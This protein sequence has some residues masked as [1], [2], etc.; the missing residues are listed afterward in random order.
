MDGLSLWNINWAWNFIF[1]IVEKYYL[2]SLKLCVALIYNGLFKWSINNHGM[3]N[4]IQD[5]VTKGP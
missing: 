3:N 4:R 5:S 1:G 2:W